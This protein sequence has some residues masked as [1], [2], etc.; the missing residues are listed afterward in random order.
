VAYLSKFGDGRH[1]HVSRDRAL[2][3]WLSSKD[4]P[5]S[6][7]N[8]FLRW[9]RKQPVPHAFGFSAS[10]PSDLSNYCG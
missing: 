9:T 4:E 3:F 7:K 10:A 2:V 8:I 5:K 6:M 1:F